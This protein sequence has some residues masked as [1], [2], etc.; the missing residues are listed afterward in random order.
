[1]I[2]LIKKI[3]EIRRFCHIVLMNYLLKKLQIIWLIKKKLKS[4]N[5]LLKKESSVRIENINKKEN[6]I[7][8]KIK[9]KSYD[10]FV[11][12]IIKNLLIKKK[13][14]EEELEEELDKEEYKKIRENIKDSY[15]EFVNDIF[16]DLIIKKKEREEQQEI[17]ELIEEIHSESFIKPKEEIKNNI[18]H[19]DD[20]LDEINE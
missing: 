15:D 12:D 18:K 5:K 13:E 20:L 2:W 1:M 7:K 14:R 17:E 8:I 3:I 19:F 9:E 6:F 4:K 16:K 11:N 10:R